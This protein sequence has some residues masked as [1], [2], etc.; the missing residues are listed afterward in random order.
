MSVKI[1]SVLLVNKEVAW[2]LWLSVETLLRVEE[3]TYLCV[4]FTRER[5][6]ERKID[7]RFIVASA[8]MQ[9]AYFFVV[10]KE[11]RLKGKVLFQFKAQAPFLLSPMVMRYGY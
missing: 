6:M 7:R 1:E 2:P 9:M 3:F 5:K 11:E 4:L 8:L 10:A